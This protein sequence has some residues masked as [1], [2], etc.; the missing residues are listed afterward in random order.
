MSKSALFWKS[1]SKRKPTGE[2]FFSEDF[3]NLVEG[4]WK[5]EP[6]KRFSIDSILSH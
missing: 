3:R 1:H 6:N 5:L 2:A 4:I